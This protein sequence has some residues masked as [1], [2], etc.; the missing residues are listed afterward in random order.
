MKEFTIRKF[1]NLR[2]EEDVIVKSH[3]EVTSDG[4]VYIDCLYRDG[5]L[6]VTREITNDGIKFYVDR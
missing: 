5:E 4:V 3:E 2:Y 6:L 1:N